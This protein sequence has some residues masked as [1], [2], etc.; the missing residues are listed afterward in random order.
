MPREGKYTSRSPAIVPVE[1]NR[2]ETGKKLNKKIAEPSARKE[3]RFQKIRMLAA[4]NK[5]IAKPIKVSK[6]EKLPEAGI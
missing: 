4:K 1:K 5:I 2:F 6:L 3:K